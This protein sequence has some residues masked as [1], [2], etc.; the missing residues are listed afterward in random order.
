VGERLAGW[1]LPCTALTDSPSLLLDL[2][3]PLTTLPTLTP[4]ADCLH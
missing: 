1:S 3:P 4:P 2:I